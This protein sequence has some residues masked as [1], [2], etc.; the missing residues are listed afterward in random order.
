MAIV[1]LLPILLAALVVA[2]LPKPERTRS[3]AA[4]SEE[5]SLVRGA[6]QEFGM[7]SQFRTRESGLQLRMWPQAAY[8]A[9]RDTSS[10]V[11]AEGLGS[12]RFGRKDN[13]DLGGAGVVFGLQTDPEEKRCVEQARSRNDERISRACPWSDEQRCEDLRS[14]S[15][16]LLARDIGRCEEAGRERARA[17][18]EA[19]REAEREAEG[20]EDRAREAREARARYEQVSRRSD[21]FFWFIVVPLIAYGTYKLA[22]AEQAKEGME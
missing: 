8:D 7:Q 11:F 3:E 9:G 1:T 15:E 14:R 5:L 16:A 22:Q 12:M 20:A 19:E 21:A 13:G 6:K 17:R 10:R 2:P 18:G 4:P